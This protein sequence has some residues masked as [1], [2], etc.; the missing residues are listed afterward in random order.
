MRGQST[1]E[2]M[3]SLGEALDDASF[4]W[5]LEQYPKVAA[6]IIQ[7]LANGATPRDV[8]YYV[9]AQTGRVELAL[10]CEQCARA[11]VRGR[12]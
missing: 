1:T 11:A 10:R 2:P 12:E 3:S 4:D 7:S 5:M 8:K 6:A 9:L